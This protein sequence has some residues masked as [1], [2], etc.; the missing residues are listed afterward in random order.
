MS[1]SKELIFQ[2][3]K[4]VFACVLAA[5]LVTMAQASEALGQTPISIPDVGIDQHLNGQV[6]LDLPLRDESGRTVQLGEYFGKKPIILTLVYYSCP[7]LC[8]LVL[9]GLTDSLSELT[10]NVGDQFNVVTVS[11]DPRETPQLAVAKKKLHI[12]QYGRAGASEGWHFLTGDEDSIKRLTS[13]VGFRYKFDTETNQFAHASGIMVLTPQG[14]IA[15]YFYGIQYPPRD[16]RLSLVDA[17]ADR[18]GSP[19]DQVLLLCYHYDL[20]LGKY[21]ARAMDVVRLG[22]G[23][24]LL[25]LAALIFRMLRKEKPKRELTGRVG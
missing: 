17:S 25:T 7:M 5:A 19:V 21:S 6:P 22:A 15:R 23:L 8:T 4:G 24:T 2:L 14:K 13:A 20:L 18:I 10:F 12:Q 9:N 16:L 1:I 11:I 3:G